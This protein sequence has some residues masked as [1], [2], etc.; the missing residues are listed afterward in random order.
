[1]DPGD[2]RRTESYGNGK[3]A[4]EYRA[5]QRKL[6]EEGRLMEAIQM[7]VDDIRAKF[8]HK[9][10]KAIEEMLNYARTLDPDDFRTRK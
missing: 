10:D 2:H 6:L 7:D 1:M 3:K 9:Y 8:G 4:V 5:K